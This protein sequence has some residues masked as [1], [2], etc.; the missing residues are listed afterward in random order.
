MGITNC[1]QWK[2]R[3]DG[4]ELKR[5][6]DGPSVSRLT[7]NLMIFDYAIKSGAAYGKE[8]SRS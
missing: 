3:R 6:I 4:G 7:S 1:R 8:S 2:G 5:H